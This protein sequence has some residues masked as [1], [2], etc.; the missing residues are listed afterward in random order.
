MLPMWIWW[1]WWLRQFCL[2]LHLYHRISS[3]GPGGSHTPIPHPNSLIWIRIFAIW[4]VCIPLNI[5][6]IPFEYLFTSIHHFVLT[7]LKIL[8]FTIEIIFSH[9]FYPCSI[10]ILLD[11]FK[12]S[13][14]I[15]HDLKLDWETW[16]MPN[17]FVWLCDCFK[18]CSC[19]RLTQ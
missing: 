16:L 12:I 19:Q 5:N 2:Y 3:E 6:D 8:F 7:R 14:L 1:I 4:Y 15:S 13:F 11:Y 17:H 9:H 10:A 18:Q